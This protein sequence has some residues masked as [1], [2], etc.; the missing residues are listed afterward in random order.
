MYAAGDTEVV[1]S[2]ST[3]IE[4]IGEDVL[5]S[6]GTADWNPGMFCLDQPRLNALSL[7]RQISCKSVSRCWKAT[8]I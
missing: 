2:L 1:E 5:T 7:G 6:E 4:T 3:M 8:V